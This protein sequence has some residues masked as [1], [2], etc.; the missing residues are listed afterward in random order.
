MSKVRPCA[1]ICHTYSAFLKQTS[2]QDPNSLQIT[3]EVFE[4]GLQITNRY[5]QYIGYHPKV[6]DETLRFANHFNGKPTAKLALGT[7]TLIV[8]FKASSTLMML[9]LSMD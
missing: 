1:L 4:Q 2:L 3:V 5:A 7:R 9:W 8:P 6:F